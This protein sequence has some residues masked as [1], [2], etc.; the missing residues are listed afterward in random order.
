MINVSEAIDLDTAIMVDLYSWQ[1]GGFDENNFY[2]G[3]WYIVTTILATPIPVAFIYEARGDELHQETQMSRIPS[4]MR[5]HTHVEVDPKDVI[6]VY[7]KG[8]RI[9]D[10]GNYSAAGYYRV[11]GE[12]IPEFEFPQIGIP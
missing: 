2:R 1:E 11:I 6:V 4:I 5:F 8:Y 12:H 10:K 7:D 3:E 9:K